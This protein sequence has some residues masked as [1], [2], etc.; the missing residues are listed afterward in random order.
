[1]YMWSSMLVYMSQFGHLFLWVLCCTTISAPGTSL[2]SLSL[3]LFMLPPSAQRPPTIVGGY[4][5]AGA[6]E[7]NAWDL[8]SLGVL[9]SLCRHLPLCVGSQVHVVLPLFG[10]GAMHVLSGGFRWP[11]A[12]AC[13]LPVPLTA[14]PPPLP[15]HHGNAAE[16]APDGSGCSA[17]VQAS[18]PLY[19]VAYLLLQMLRLVG[20]CPTEG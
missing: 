4:Y 11:S 3:G 15:P 1:M 19:R 16:R 10:G 13:I 5:A 17:H 14:C 8:R 20:L 12:H 6:P 7:V 9:P 2:V 18:P